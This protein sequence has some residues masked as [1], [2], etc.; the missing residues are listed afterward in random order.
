MEVLFE[1]RSGFS[2]FRIVWQCSGDDRRP[3]PP[4]TEMWWI[5]LCQSEKLDDF[6]RVGVGLIAL[7]RPRWLREVEEFLLSRLQSDKLL[8][9]KF[10]GSQVD[11]TDVVKC[12]LWISIIQRFIKL[13]LFSIIVSSDHNSFMIGKTQHHYPEKISTKP[14]QAKTQTKLQINS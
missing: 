2:S 7:L 12:S 13:K 14:P 5:K 3:C 1:A 4:A 9:D 8:Q 10:S 11:L 6:L